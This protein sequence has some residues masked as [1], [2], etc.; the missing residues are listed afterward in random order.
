LIYAAF[1]FWLL[2]ILFAGVGVYRLWTWLAKPT[3]VNWVLLPGTVV[4]EMGYIFGCLVT[5]GEIRR[6]RLLPQAKG[7]GGKEGEPQTEASAGVKYVGPIVASLI[8]IL[9]CG[10]SILASHA[11]LGKPVIDVFA[12]SGGIMQPAALPQELPAGWQGFWDQATRQVWL[13]RRMCE[14]WGQINWLDWRVPL[15][16]YVSLCLSVRL[17]PVSRP[18]RASLAA[19]VAVAAVIAATGLGWP[20]FSSLMQAVWPLLTYVWASLLFLLA[21]TLLGLGLVRLGRALASKDGQ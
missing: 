1:T 3:W 21:V 17:S 9:A 13:L 10:A 4:S 2:M 14:T 20:R 6:A 11:L 15:F 12:T 7:N 5:G 18:I 8:S 19:A 16:V